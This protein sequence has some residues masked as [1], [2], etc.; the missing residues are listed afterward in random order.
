MALI[1]FDIDNR[2]VFLLGLIE[3]R[4]RPI[5]EGYYRPKQD[6]ALSVQHQI[7]LIL[8]GHDPLMHGLI[9]SHAE[10]LWGLTGAR[11]VLK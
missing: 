3:G 6:D 4:I 7:L 9:G 2:D 5:E 8:C 11:Q 1:A 10:N